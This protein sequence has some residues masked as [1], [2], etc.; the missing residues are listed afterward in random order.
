MCCSTSLCC[1]HVPGVIYGTVTTSND[2]LYDLSLTDQAYGNYIA[3]LE[4]TIGGVQYSSLT[5]PSVARECDASRVTHWQTPPSGD[6]SRSGWYTSFDTLHTALTH[7]SCQHISPHNTCWE[8]LVT[9]HEHGT[10]SG[11]TNNP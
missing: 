9:A 1:L 8:L 2:V 10:V 3:S 11:T 7:G 6:L 4:H 5:S